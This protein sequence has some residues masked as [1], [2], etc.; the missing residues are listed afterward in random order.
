[1]AG[2]FPASLNP[3]QRLGAVLYAAGLGGIGVLS[4]H[5]QD[6]A[7][8]W[9]PVPDGVPFRS[10][11][12]I[13]SGTILA[14]GGVSVLAGFRRR[15]GALVLAVFVLIWLLLLQVPRVA[16]HPMDEGMW[17]GFGE[18]MLTV[19]GGFTLFCVL[20]PAPAGGAVRVVRILFAL[21]LPVIGYSHFV[22]TQAT[23]SMVPAW[24]PFHVGFAYLTG[25]GHMAAGLGILLGVFPRLAAGMEAAMISCFVLLLHIPGVVSAPGDRLQ[26]T[27]L[28]IATAYAGS[29]WIVAGSVPTRR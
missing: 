17:L 20:G 11:L 7:M 16:A 18:N 3:M 22:Y 5:Y 12:A 9:Q 26:W 2:E 24:I 14:C 28:C 10:V 23:A 4:L 25:A 21:F 15:L 13:L 29:C 19:A 27:M 8:A 1:M 6:F